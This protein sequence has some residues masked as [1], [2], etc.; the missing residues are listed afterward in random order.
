MPAAR[1][2]AATAHRLAAVVSPLMDL[3][4]LQKQDRSGTQKA[5][6]ADHPRGNAGRIEHHMIVPDRMAEAISGN[7]HRQGSPDAY[8]HMRAQ[9]AAHSSRPRFTPITDPST[10]AVRS[11]HQVYI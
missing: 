6:A 10:A 5:D 2:T 4:L 9:A 8:Q 11:R 7:N 3:F 1:P